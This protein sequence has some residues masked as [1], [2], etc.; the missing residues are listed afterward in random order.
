MKRPPIVVRLCPNPTWIACDNGAP[1][2]VMSQSKAPK[3]HHLTRCAQ[4]NGA[5]GMSSI[6]SCSETKEPGPPFSRRSSR[7][8]VV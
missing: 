1:S 3:D 5:L 8:T 2:V 6:T 7:S 4:Y